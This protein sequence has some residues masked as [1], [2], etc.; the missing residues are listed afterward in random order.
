MRAGCGLLERA[1]KFKV[2]V[3]EAEGKGGN[4]RLPHKE[5]LAI[6][7]QILGERLP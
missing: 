2:M 4:A 1:E 6:R 3:H 7:K 5:L